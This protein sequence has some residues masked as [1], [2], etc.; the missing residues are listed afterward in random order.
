MFQKL[1]REGKSV[2]A[3][4]FNVKGPDLLWLDKPAQPEPEWAEAYAA[5]EA[6]L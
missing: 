1:Q 3:L 2:A 4:M 6:K 5:A